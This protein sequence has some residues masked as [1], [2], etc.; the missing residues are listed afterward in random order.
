MLNSFREVI[1]LWSSLRALSEEPE[2]GANLMAVRKWQQRD[3]IPSEEWI[4]LAKAAQRRGFGEMTVE[5]LA[6]LKAAKATGGPRQPEP[7]P[8]EAFKEAS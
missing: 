7:E 2:V 5:L 8:P 3:S 6:E 4:G 1:G